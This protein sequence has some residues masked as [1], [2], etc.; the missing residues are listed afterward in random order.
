MLLE[1]AWENLPEPRPPLT[2]EISDSGASIV[3][4]FEPH[5][6]EVTANG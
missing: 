3:F 4:A 5:L 1:R 2:F 6:E